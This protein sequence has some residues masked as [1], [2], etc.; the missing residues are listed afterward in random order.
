MYIN[1][2]YPIVRSEDLSMDTPQKVTVLSTN[3]VAFRDEDGRPLWAG[4]GQ[5]RNN[6]A[7]GTDRFGRGAPMAGGRFNRTAP[8]GNG[9]DNDGR[10]RLFDNRGCDECGES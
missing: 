8:R 2:W 6:V 10:G 5:R 3:L 4:Q 1:F 7:A 9:R